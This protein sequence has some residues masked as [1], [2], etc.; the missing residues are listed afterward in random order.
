M[1]RK[2]SLWAILLGTVGS[3]FFAAGTPVRAYNPDHVQQLLQTNSCPYCDLSSANL[4]GAYLQGA[5]LEG[6]NLSFA[7]LRYADLSGAIL[8]GANL[9]GA[10]TEGTI[11]I[12]VIW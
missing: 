6:A 2:L 4:E 10:N 12:G 8:R 3:V 1:K 7:N 5:N 11:F 9:T